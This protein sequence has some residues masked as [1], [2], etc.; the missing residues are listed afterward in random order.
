[1]TFMRV[2]DAGY[3]GEM[4]KHSLLVLALSAC[5]DNVDTQL[6]TGR[7]GASFPT[8]ISSVEVLK[9]GRAVATSNVATDG[10]FALIVH[11]G[12]GLSL[13]LVSATGHSTTVFPRVAGTIDRSFEVHGAGVP[14][15]LGTLHYVSTLTTKPFAFKT[16]EE[17]ATTCDDDGE[18][19]DGAQCVDDGDNQGGECDDEDGEHEDDGEDEGEEDGEDE[20][21]ADDDGGANEGQNGADEGDAVA[22]HNFPEDGCADG[23]DNGGDDDDEDDDG[24]DD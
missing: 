19:A 12:R 11:P 1:M 16:A 15:D 20:D 17:Q 22:D 18:D 13:H 6:I 5:G 24:D 10:S 14:F 21:E 2:V 9:D 8:P 7:I 4:W 3:D 23:D